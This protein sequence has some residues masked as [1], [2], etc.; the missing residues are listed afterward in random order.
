MKKTAIHL[1][2]AL[3]AVLCHAASAEDRVNGVV[4]ASHQ[5]Y[6]ADESA[7]AEYTFALDNGQKYIL[8][9]REAVVL[10]T[11]QE[12]SLGL[13][14]VQDGKDRTVVCSI[15]FSRLVVVTDAGDKHFVE[16]D[17]P[18]VYRAANGHGC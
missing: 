11:D 17:T 15:A 4:K 9:T 8:Y 5:F 13:S 16:M 2:S 6:P 10:M 12:V 1:T 3:I 18:K 14:P 7:P